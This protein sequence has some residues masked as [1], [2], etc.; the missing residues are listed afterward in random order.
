M[1]K[2]IL[3]CLLLLFALVTTGC[4]HNTITGSFLSDNPKVEC[5]DACI[6]EGENMDTC[7]MKCYGVYVPENT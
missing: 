7:K 2:V 6:A 4:T 1:R 3:L 5:I